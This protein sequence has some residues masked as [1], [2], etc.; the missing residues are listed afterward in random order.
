MTVMAMMGLRIDLFKHKS[1]IVPAVSLFI[2]GHVYS[3]WFIYTDSMTENKKLILLYVQAAAF[4][5]GYYLYLCTF[6]K[7]TWYLKQRIG[8]R[9]STIA[10]NV[11]MGGLWV[12]NMA[13]FRML[14]HFDHG[15][16]HLSTSHALI[17]G[18]IGYIM[19]AVG[20]IVKIWASYILG[21]A[22]YFYADMVHRKPLEGS[23]FNIIGPYK[24]LNNP[25]YGLGY[26]G[27]YGFALVHQSWMCLA[28]SAVMHAGVWYFNTA[29]EQ[30][31][32]KKI[33]G[34][35]A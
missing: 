20:W 11:S 35:N 29:V 34:D 9:S 26:V 17:V 1:Y 28:M 25:M 30:K 8:D 31:W 24:W 2:L 6:P 32:V 10:F 18:V 16:M 12:F 15:S 27:C 21:V 19:S 13:I 5:F 7:W 23:T 3:N 14:S 4:P 33:Y 22:S